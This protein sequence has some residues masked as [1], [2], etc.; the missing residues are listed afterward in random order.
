MKRLAVVL[1]IALSSVLLF[2]A[3]PATAAAPKACIAALDAA[4]DLRSAFS[5]YTT[6]TSDMISSNGDALASAPPTAAGWTRALREYSANTRAATRELKSVAAT[7]ERA[8]ARY[9]AA[10]EK[11]RDA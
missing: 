2:P 5:D 11:C 7:L 6:I 4:E 3:G 8:R 1:L 9:D 10:A